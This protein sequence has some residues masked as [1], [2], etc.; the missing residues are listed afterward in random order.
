[1]CIV[2]CLVYKF[3]FIIKD[4]FYS[5]IKFMIYSIYVHLIK[6]Q[7]KTAKEIIK[8]YLCQLT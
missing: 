4:I 5:E 3:T 2:W 7:K 8:N 1:M 6:V